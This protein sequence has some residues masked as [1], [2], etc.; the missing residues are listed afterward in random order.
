MKVGIFLLSL[1]G[2]A[3]KGGFFNYSRCV[4]RSL[5]ELNPDIEIFVF[6]NREATP[7]LGFDFE[8]IKLVEKN[9][10]KKFPQIFEP[11]S[12]SHFIE[13]YKLDVIHF[14]IYGGPVK[15]KVPLIITV[16]DLAFLM[17]RKF[18]EG[19]LNRFY[20]L[21]IFKKGVSKASRLIAVSEN[22]KKD[23]IEHW[24]IDGRKIEIVFNGSMFEYFRPK[25]VVDVLKKFGLE[26]NRYF[27][28]VGTIEPRKNHLRVL[29]AFDKFLKKE[30]KNFKLVIVGK[31]GWGRIELFK[32]IKDLKIE[33][34]VV[35]TDFISD[36]ELYFL[37]KNS[38]ALLY[39][40]LYEGFGLPLIEAMSLGTPVL[41]SDISPLSDIVNNAGIK[42][43]PYSIEEIYAGLRKLY[44]DER[45]LKEIK[46][47][48]KE[49]VKI[50]SW[51]KHGEKL[52]E[53][54][55]KEHEK[56]KNYSSG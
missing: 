25:R 38:R 44:R 22:T 47:K 48:A 2:K 43:N 19:F 6:L 54:Y 14:P 1:K 40:S 37:Y 42:V 29:K 18:I 8:N 49:R 16:H 53:I 17:N 55:K 4:L 33:K 26:K 41:T 34:K 12:V 5:E 35:F 36:D 39:P 20:W 46:S 30:E 11:Y 50:F 9:F 31:R 52:I 23:L 15:K 45:F 3:L 21:K 13:K 7:F 27:L 51:R 56:I 24:K 32:K 10:I 28:M